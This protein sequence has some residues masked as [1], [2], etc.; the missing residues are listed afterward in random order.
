M[1]PRMFSYRVLINISLGTFII[2]MHRECFQLSV[3]IQVFAFD[4]VSF[5]TDFWSTYIRYGVGNYKVARI[6]AA[7]LGIPEEGNNK[8]V[9]IV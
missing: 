6:Y 8:S 3:D 9:N 7:Y 5:S 2:D 1:H 4:K